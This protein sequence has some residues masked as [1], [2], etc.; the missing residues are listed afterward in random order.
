MIRNRKPQ[1]LMVQSG[2]IVFD[3]HRRAHGGHPGRTHHT[4]QHFEHKMVKQM[5]AASAGHDCACYGLFMMEMAQQDGVLAPGDNTC[6]STQLQVR[7]LRL[8]RVGQGATF[9]TFGVPCTR[10]R[11]KTVI[12][13]DHRCSRPA[14]YR[15]RRCGI[16]NTGRGNIGARHYGRTRQCHL[17]C[18]VHCRGFDR[19][20]PFRCPW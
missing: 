18:R 2:K 11:D 14:S 20:V 9:G 6:L 3:Q 16:G 8:G 15:H 12:P 1:G 10:A 19:F 7:I 5:A 17:P 4:R 13:A